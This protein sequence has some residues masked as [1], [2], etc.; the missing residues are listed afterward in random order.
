MR[1]GIRAALLALA[2][3]LFHAP[4]AR[5][6]D[7]RPDKTR[8]TVMTYNAEFMWD[9]VA[10]EEGNV[11][12]PRKGNKLLAEAHMQKVAAVIIA[13]DPD[14]VNL[15]EVENLAALTALNDKFLIGRGYKPYLVN[16]TDVSTGQDVGLLTR[17]DPAAPPARDD[18]KG[19]SGTTRKAVSKNYVAR[20]P[21]GT[22]TVA[23]IGTHL[24]ARP[25]DH[26]RRFQR[27]AQA[28]AIRG[29]ARDRAA[30]GDQVIVL[31]DLNDYDGS[32]A[33]ADHVNSLPVSN[34]LQILRSM[35]PADPADD[36][37]NVAALVPKGVRYTAF[38]DQN[39]NGLVDSPAELTGI[40]H[41]LVSATLRAAID[42]ADMPHATPAG[43]VS[44]HFPVVVRFKTPAGGGGAAPAGRVRITRLLPNPFGDET[45]NET[46]TLKNLSPGPV[47]LTGWK[48]RDL[49]GKTWKLDG[50]GTLAA[51]AEA[52]IERDGQEMALN[53][54]G[55]TVDLI[56]PAGAIVQT[57]TYPSFVHDEGDE[58]EIDTP[59]PAP[60]AP[61]P[62]VRIGAL[63]IEWLG[64]PGS[65]A[66][67]AKDLAQDPKDIAGYIRAGGVAV[68][69][70]EEIGDDDGAAAT[71]TNKT[72]DAAVAELNAGGSAQWKYRLFAK[73]P[74]SDTPD[75]QLTGLA[76]NEAVV[77]PV[78][79][80][81]GA[82]D[83]YRLKLTLPAGAADGV[84]GKPAFE[85]W[86]TA[87][88]FSAGKGKTDF[89]VVPV[90]LKSNRPAVPGQDVVKLRE[91]EAGMLLAALADL[92]ARFADEDIVVLGDT[93]VMKA[94]E[95][96]VGKFTA[97]GFAD[98]N[99]AD[100]PS[101][102]AGS[103]RKPF[104]RAFVPNAAGNA[105]A[106]EF[107]DPRFDVFEH[108]ALSA[109]DYRKKVSDHRMI[110]LTVG[111][112]ADD[113]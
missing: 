103:N 90:H 98:L 10:P 83:E 82:A 105:A 50:L 70:L 77:T 62:A 8:L 113:D 35:D 69:A 41:I 101:Y 2:G 76:W 17:I 42:V 48:L 36:L 24:L 45:K 95:A 87:M 11:E 55:D 3:L 34:V 20:L 85:R 7:R 104:D 6:D 89:V 54:G 39:Q 100:V 16:G 23:V 27:E 110:R 9:G 46:A 61:A 92:A 71:R 86:A 74:G 73:H 5:A 65:R 40:D 14:V 84:P 91:V 99:A 72:L 18:R 96:A 58:F 52:T 88:K 4:T 67:P 78:K 112:S 25:G 1:H 29:M 60:P 28:D 108:P 33:A 93:N 32:A 44:D 22:T 66:A 111:V 31:G 53:N 57:V 30:A 49:A 56:D 107:A 75:T 64:N 102:G 68:L 106:K 43:S 21:V 51:G 38:W 94:T 97:A 47:D 59:A 37:F 81:D 26:S 12:F 80:A 19:A 15:V 79:T 63:N 109:A 13:S